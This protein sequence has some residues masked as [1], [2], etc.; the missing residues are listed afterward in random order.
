MVQVTRN[1]IM[2]FGP[3]RSD[4][5]PASGTVL[6]KRSTAPR[7]ET[8]AQPGLGPVCELPDI[9]SSLTKD[10]LVVHGQAPAFKRDGHAHH[11]KHR[12]HWKKKAKFHQS[13]LH[14]DGK[15]EHIAE[16]ANAKMTTRA[17]Q[18]IATEEDAEEDQ[19]DGSKS[20]YPATVVQPSAGIV[21]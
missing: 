9:D 3:P 4:C 1:G 2:V 16:E 5:K 8:S 13:G 17:K 19:S 11:K 18:A 6:P 10:A 15:D 14:D 20:W 12:R 21:R 7:S